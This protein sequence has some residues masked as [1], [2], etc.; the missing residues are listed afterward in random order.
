MATVNSLVMCVLQIACP[1]V[2]AQGLWG[3]QPDVTGVRWG[4]LDSV[5]Q[6]SAGPLRAFTILLWL[7][8]LRTAQHPAFSKLI[9]AQNVY[10][11]PQRVLL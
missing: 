7:G 9:S 6:E 2:H 11:F 10:I 1:K 3:C 5:G 8:D 4:M